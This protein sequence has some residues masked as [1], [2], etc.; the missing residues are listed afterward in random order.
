[1]NYGNKLFNNDTRRNR[2]ISILLFWMWWR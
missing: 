2:T 1:V